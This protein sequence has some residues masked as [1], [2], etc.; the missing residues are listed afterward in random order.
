MLAGKRLR[1][2]KLSIEWFHEA[3]RTGNVYASYK[4]IPED[5]DYIGTFYDYTDDTISAIFRHESFDVIGA[6][7]VKNLNAIHISKIPTV[8]RILLDQL[9]SKVDGQ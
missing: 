3:V 4:T 6:K 7:E 9:I 2:V 5:A 8:T 1:K